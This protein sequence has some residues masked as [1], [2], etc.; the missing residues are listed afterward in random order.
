MTLVPGTPRTVRF[1]PR[2]KVTADRFRRGMSV[3][4]LRDTYR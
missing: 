3:R 1:N 4:H 2:E